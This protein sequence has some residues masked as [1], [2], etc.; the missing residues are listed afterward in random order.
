MV[1]TALLLL[2]AATGLLLARAYTPEV[3]SAYASAHSLTGWLA[4]L[5][6]LQYWGG[7]LALLIAGLTT[8]GMLWYGWW[9]H[10]RALWLLMLGLFATTLL[11]HVSGKPLPLSRHD[12]RTIVVEARI[13]G[14][15]PMIGDTL[16]SWLLPENRVDDRA[17]QNWYT[18]H[19]T[20][21]GILAP[22][23]ALCMLIVLYRSG[24]RA[25]VALVA[26]AIALGFILALLGAPSG[27]AAQPSDL[28]GGAVSPMWYV[29]PL[30]ALLRWSQSFSPE[31][32]WVGAS[33]VPLAAFLF[34]FLLP[35]FAQYRWSSVVARGVA[36][37]GSFVVV[38]AYAQFGGTMQNPLTRAT[39]SASSTAPDPSRED[40]NNRLISSGAEVFERENCRSCHTLDGVGARG[41]GPALDTVG[42][43]FQRRRE[44]MEFLRDPA[45]Q[46]AALMP[47]Y[48]SLSE[49][50]LAAL[51]EFLRAQTD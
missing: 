3:D 24:L 31:L 10:G 2:I 9:K 22:T 18:L 40:V 23:L 28:N 21:G 17:L 46:G 44:L 37:I 45:A 51:A 12:A 48:D 30:H 1:V 50:D 26:L 49:E 19:R 8:F 43:R 14:L 47:S 6:G 7:N 11:A 34:L 25:S 36:L 29:I 35:W 4:Y 5:R 41:P 20:I 32:G 27:E 38:A 33:L 16:Q 42:K 13:A 39:V 15:T